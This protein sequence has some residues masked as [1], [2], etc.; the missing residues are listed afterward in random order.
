MVEMCLRDIATD[1]VDSRWMPPLRFGS[2]GCYGWS[3]GVMGKV[4]MKIG[5]LPPGWWLELDETPS[6]TVLAH[7]AVVIAM[8]AEDVQMPVLEL[9]APD[10]DQEMAVHHPDSCSQIARCPA[11]ASSHVR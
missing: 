8:L 6:E 3:F 2:G 10:D 4:S 1:W 5:E 9:E 7:L 11:S